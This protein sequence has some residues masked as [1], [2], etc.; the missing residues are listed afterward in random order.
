MCPLLSE[1]TSEASRGSSRDYRGGV[2]ARHGGRAVGSGSGDA[3][4]A[5]I[6][7][8]IYG[9][10]R[11]VHGGDDRPSCAGRRDG[12]LGT[13]PWREP[14]GGAVLPE[15]PAFPVGRDRVDA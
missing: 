13:P 1:V 12:E 10:R 14:A 4:G 7:A 3:D 11:A 15:D 8:A 2:G 6:G 9:G 5:A